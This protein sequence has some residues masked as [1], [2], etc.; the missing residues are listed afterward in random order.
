MKKRERGKRRNRGRKKSHFHIRFPAKR[1]NTKERKG[2]GKIEKK[3]KREIAPRRRSLAWKKKGKNRRS[4]RPICLFFSFLFWFP[5]FLPLS[6][7]EANFRSQERRLL[8]RARHGFEPFNEKKATKKREA[9]RWNVEN[10][11][12]MKVEKERKTKS[13]TKGLSRSE[14]CQ[15]GIRRTEHGEALVARK[16]PGGEIFVRGYGGGTPTTQAG[17]SLSRPCYRLRRRRRPRKKKLTI[18]HSYP[19]RG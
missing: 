11:R 15:I 13:K 10:S 5:F 7:L 8:S 1:R 14:I 17:I 19:N 12:A 6:F 9:E 4:F 2:K 3:G 18:P 16:W